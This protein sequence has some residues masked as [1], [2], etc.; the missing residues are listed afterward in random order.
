MWAVD[1]KQDIQLLWPNYELFSDPTQPLLACTMQHVR[2]S[3]IASVVVAEIVK[4]IIV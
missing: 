4:A 1:E 2:P 3:Y